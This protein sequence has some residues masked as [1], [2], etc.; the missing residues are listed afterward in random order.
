MRILSKIHGK[1]LVLDSIFDKVAGIQSPACKLVK[2]DI[3]AQVFWGKFCKIFGEYL[4][5]YRTASRDSYCNLI[6][7]KVRFLIYF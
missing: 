5:L 2:N 4:Y 7:S 3:T 1:T 6:I